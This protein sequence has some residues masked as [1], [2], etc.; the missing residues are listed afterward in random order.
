MTIEAAA[1]GGKEGTVELRL[2]LRNPTVST[3]SESLHRCRRRRAGLGRARH[4]RAPS[5]CAVSTLDALIARYGEPRFVKIDVEGFED[6]VLAGLSHPLPALSVEFTTIQRDVALAAIARLARTGAYFF[7]ATIGE[8]QRFVHPEPLDATGIA[9][10]L[11][12]LPIEA[13]SGDIYAALDALG[14]CAK[15]SARTRRNSRFPSATRVSYGAHSPN[16]PAKPA[17]EEL[18]ADPVPYRRDEASEQPPYDYP[19]YEST[20]KRHPD[21]RLVILPHTLSEVTGPVYG[22]GKVLP[23]D[24]DLTRQ[25]KGDP[26]GER[27]V[28]TGRVLDE[29]GRPTPHTLVEIWQANA[30]GRYVHARD[31]HPAPLDANFTGAGRAVT[32][33]DG[34][35]RF[36]T[37]K[38]GAYPWRNHPNAWRPAHIHFSVFGAELHHPAG[39][40]DVFPRRSAVSVRSRLQQHPRRQGARTHGRPLRP[41]HYRAGMGARLSVRHRAAR[42]RE[43]AGALT[44][45]SGTRRRRPSGHFSPSA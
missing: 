18:M 10:W 1:L 39:D 31:Q 37:I 34:R 38:P 19:A 36:V 12:G 40:A 2:N 22:H 16:A 43:D 8:S 4:G 23:E 13:N 25:H 44:W 41:R 15:S 32:D 27:I 30:A 17:I 21:Q 20:A 14:H 26:V 24:A 11:D 3:A 28:V 45:R 35:Y 42:A 9:R 33:A 5:R 6:E 29:N 7:N